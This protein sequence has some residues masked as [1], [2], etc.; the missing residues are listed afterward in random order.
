MNKFRTTKGGRVDRS[1]PLTFTFNGKDYRAYKGDTLASALLA[2]G[3]HFVGR[4]FKY[5]R[6][7]GILTA[8]SEEPNAL[9][10]LDR[11]HGREEPNNRA[12]VSEVYE[13][14]Q[15]VSQN[16]WP[17][18]SCDVGAINDRLGMLFTAGFYYKTF[19]WPRS[20]WNKVYEP[21]IRNAA[22][23]GKSPTR[24]DPD[25]YASRYEHC[26]ILIVGSGAAG[27]AA[28]LAAGQAGARVILVDEQAELGGSL[29]SEA[30]A[31]IDGHPA[32]KWV[33]ETSKVLDSLPNVTTLTRTTA[34]GYYHYNMVGLCQRVTDHMVKAPADAPRERLWRVRAKQVVLAQGAI[35]KPLVFPD[36]DRPG[37]M[38]A[39]AARSYLNRYGVLIGKRAV[40]AT[41][42]DSAWGAAFDLSLAGVNVC[43]IVDLRK[44]VAQELLARAK[45]LGIETLVGWT[46]SGTAGRKR[47]ASVRINPLTGSRGVGGGRT[48][49][50]DALLTSGGWTPSV[51]LFSHTKGELVWND[52]LECF[53]PGKSLE[54]LQCVGAG[55]GI[56]GIEHALNTGD[57][58]GRAAASA[59]GGRSN[60]DRLFVVKG[61]ITFNGVSQRDLP[62]EL[63]PDTA[64]AFVDQQNDVT[65]K[66]IRLAVREG[67][68]SIE[69]I[70]RY[71]TNG[72]A[73]DQGKTSN[74][75]GLA[76]AAEALGKTP[77]AVGLTTFRPPFTPTTFGAFAGYRRREHFDVTRKT[78]MD[79][80]AV[81]ANAV[82]EP[83]GLWRR[84]FYFPRQGENMHQA[85]MRE[86][87]AVREKV[88][89]FDASTLGK[90]EVVG[91]D[92]A[93]FLNR[94]YINSW[95]KLAPGRCRY[96]LLLGEDGYIRDDGVIGRIAEDRFHV[97]TTTGGAARVFG[98]MEDYR[99]TE[100][101]ELNVWLT[102]TT[103]QWAVMALNGPNARK[104]IEP[105]IEGID[106]SPNSFPHMSVAEG[107]I[108]GVPLRLF[109][110]S[111]SGE[112]GFEV[113]VPARYGLGVW[114]E[115]M[116]TGASWGIQPYG[117]EAMHILRAEKGY[118][119]VGQDTD[120]TVTPADAGYGRMV[121]NS[122]PDFVGKRGLI[123]PDLIA[124]GRR[125]VVGLLT[126]DPNVVLEEGAQ[127]VADPNQS[128]PMKMIGHVTS[129]YHSVA[130]GRSIAM[131]L[132]ENGQDLIGR[133][134]HI[135][136]PD[137]THVAQITGTVFY[138]PENKRLEM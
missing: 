62:G 54:A 123:R 116:R 96:G 33:E 138:D 60:V 49:T 55:T 15:A 19:M 87:R 11:G 42:H 53:L 135:P 105:L 34:I 28:A 127:V 47:V 23:L 126:K 109:R 132:V 41:S 35:E 113:N 131:A 118:I 103:E 14:M 78:P 100:W 64:K 30:A 46:V 2:N 25:A 21:I 80:A 27:L 110:V 85:V 17:S 125:Q 67:F 77:P 61:E 22:G 74:I 99:Q 115:L 106:L 119:I 10:G 37:I 57:A 122:K 50:C 120:G 94:M 111:F 101:P 43:A 7:R 84:A 32:A 129:S 83:V 95:T 31:V 107:K 9:V 4:S 134:V 44:S 65:A 117:T 24:P 76:I 72:M 112:L 75:N 82:W 136:M 97:T 89:I 36:N 56:F 40:V 71:T 59:V 108:C 68:R 48:I 38:L 26:D 93:E 88:G 137:R 102:S 63:N 13:G 81:A 16:H 114:Q 91:P 128:I 12:T 69:H 73:T 39:N 121:A 130:L 124:P 133:D 92:A 51:H 5:H 1:T 66:D 58:A 52:T 6:P 45:E 79:S 18:L 8:G 90:I 20:F 104:V 70:K 86:C 29:L 3:I 98:T